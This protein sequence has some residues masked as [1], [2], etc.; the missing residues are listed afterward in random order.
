MSQVKC[1]SSIY[2]GST[3]SCSFSIALDLPENIFESV[4]W[5][6]KCGNLLLDEQNLDT[7]AM[8]TVYFVIIADK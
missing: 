3:S 6:E 1:I 7:E 5:I 4:S 8:E 2:T